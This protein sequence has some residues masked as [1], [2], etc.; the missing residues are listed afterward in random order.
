MGCDA[1]RTCDAIVDIMEGIVKASPVNL[2][3]KHENVVQDF[4]SVEIEDN[5][6]AKT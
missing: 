6:E 5:E 4:S 3:N 1:S 2:Q